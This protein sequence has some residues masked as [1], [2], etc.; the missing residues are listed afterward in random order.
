MMVR[1]YPGMLGLGV[2]FTFFYSKVRDLFFGSALQG[3]SHVGTPAFGCGKPRLCV[4]RANGESTTEA[5]STRP[6][7]KPC[8]LNP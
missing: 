1:P 8:T 2:L 5:L 4:P 3:S 6:K 7:P